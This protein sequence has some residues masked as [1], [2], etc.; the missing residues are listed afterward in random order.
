MRQQSARRWH[1][2]ACASFRSRAPKIRR[3]WRKT[4]DLLIKQQTMN[5]NSGRLSEF[6][7]AAAK[8]VGRVEELIEKAESDSALPEPIKAAVKVFVAILK[9]I[10][11][12]IAELDEQIGHAHEQ[13][14]RSCLL[15]AIPGIGNSPQSLTAIAS[16]AY[17]APARFGGHIA[18]L[19]HQQTQGRMGR[20]VQSFAKAKASAACYFGARQQAGADRGRS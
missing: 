2:R 1:G 17:K 10:R 4:R 3:R 11:A 20:L 12:Q 18:S 14:E 15:R 16:L 9:T 7:I 6:G 13:N 8:G 19:H 5:V